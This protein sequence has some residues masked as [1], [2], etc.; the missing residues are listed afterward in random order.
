MTGILALALLAALVVLTLERTHR[1]HPRG[2][3]LGGADLRDDADLRRHRSDRDWLRQST[4]TPSPALPAAECE[5]V[6]PWEMSRRS[7]APVP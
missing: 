6:A 3:Y 2:P 1:R 4:T 7:S 5:R